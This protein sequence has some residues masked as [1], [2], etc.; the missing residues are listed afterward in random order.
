MTAL[1][2][3]LLRQTLSALV[4][5]PSGRIALIPLTPSALILRGKLIEAGIKE[6][7]LA[8]FDS[9]LPN[10]DAQL[11]GPWDNLL[12]MPDLVVVTTDRGKEDV[13]R[14]LSSVWRD[15]RE[16]PRVIL[17]GVAHQTFRDDIFDELDRPALVPSYATGHTHT[18]IHIYQCL[19][20]AAANKLSGSVVEFGAFK[21]GT[22]AWLART[23]K[24]LGINAPVIGFDSWTGFPPRRSL[25]DL[26]AHPRCV[27]TD[28][29]EVKSHLDPLGVELVAGDIVDTADRLHGQPVLLAFIDTDNYSPARAAIDVVLPN[30]VQ[31]GAIILDHF[32]TSR[33]YAY[34]VGERLAAQELLA[35]SGLLN[36]HGTG[37]F[38]RIAR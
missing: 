38:V 12:D 17:S 2:D 19:R 35:S 36:L 34:T 29:Q 31:G 8:I 23:V 10:G 28:L 21:G 14:S 5:R 32:F 33:D 27:F 6:E 30:L 16:L 7:A 3:D 1:V 22:T 37:V 15:Q 4:E 24:R 11:V 9:S 20:A 18:R 26:Y 25:L 13:L